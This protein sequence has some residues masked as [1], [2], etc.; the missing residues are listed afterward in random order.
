[1]DRR[2]EVETR[3]YA[4]PIACGARDSSPLIAASAA[5]G[6]A[7]GFASQRAGGLACLGPATGAVAGGTGNQSEPTALGAFLTCAEPRRP[8]GGLLCGNSRHGRGR[9]ETSAV[10]RGDGAGRSLS[11]KKGSERN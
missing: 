1:M 7:G 3:N 6:L 10:Q 9:H 2:V 8:L 11:H 4:N 5:T